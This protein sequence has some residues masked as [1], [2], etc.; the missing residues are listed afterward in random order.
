M[1]AVLAILLV[2]A[3]ACASSPPSHQPRHRP[4]DCESGMPDCDAMFRASMA[5]MHKIYDDDLS[6]FSERRRQA[7][8]KGVH[9]SCYSYRQLNRDSA[10]LWQRLNQSC[11]RLTLDEVSC[12][13]LGYAGR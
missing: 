5:C 2:L 7:M 1:R 4:F 9:D 12:D 3:S 13:G 10:A 11:R 8:V 6:S